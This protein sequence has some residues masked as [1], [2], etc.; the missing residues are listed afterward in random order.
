MPRCVIPGSI[1][2]ALLL[3]WDALLYLLG[4]FY[5]GF[6]RCHVLGFAAVYYTVAQRFH[7]R[8]IRTCGVSSYMP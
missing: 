1:F 8:S 7:G 3:S 2:R 6:S 4:N 5:A